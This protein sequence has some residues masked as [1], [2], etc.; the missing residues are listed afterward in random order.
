MFLEYL[1]LLLIL[2]VLVMLFYTFIYIHELPYETAKH[3]NHPH[4][5][6]IFV[7]CWLSLFTLHAIWPLVYIWALTHKEPGH[8]PTDHAGAGEG[9]AHV[10]SAGRIAQLEERLKRLEERQSAAK[11]GSIAT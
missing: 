3:R 11:K 10:D 6:A 7:A 8:E 1:A 2:V 4:Q 9:A 5:D